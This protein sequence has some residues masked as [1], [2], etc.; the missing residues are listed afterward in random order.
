M[1]PA[2]MM[3]L[4]MFMNALFKPLLG[5][6][7]SS[8]SSGLKSMSFATVTLGASMPVNSGARCPA[9]PLP[10]SPADSAPMESSS[11]TQPS[12]C[13]DPFGSRIASGSAKS[14][15]TRCGVLGVPLGLA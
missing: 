15:R 8:R 11:S 3:L 13:A 10:S 4:A 2:P 1:M 14:K 6:A 5:L 9:A 12:A 7:D